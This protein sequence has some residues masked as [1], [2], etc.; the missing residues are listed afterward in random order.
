MSAKRFVLL[1]RDGTINVERGYLA[2]PA[3]LELIRGAAD[4]LRQLRELGLGLVVITNQSGIGRGLFDAG[5]L[6]LVHDRLR[7]LLAAEGVSLDGIYVCPHHPDD[8][9]TC[10]KPQTGLAQQAARELGFAGSETFVI[11]DKPS[12]VR[13]G[14]NIGATTVLVRTGYGAAACRAWETDAA[15]EGNPPPDHVATDLAEAAGTIGQMIR[16][17]AI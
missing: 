10:R 9:C 17:R 11:G 2:D 7:R 15:Q 16:N 1:D 5:Q 13:L 12:D 8:R 6:A 4:G 14:H 3:D